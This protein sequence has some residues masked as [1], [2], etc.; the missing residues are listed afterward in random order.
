MEIDGLAL[1]FGSQKVVDLLEDKKYNMVRLRRCITLAKMGRPK[2]ENP[3]DFKV[4]ARLT[5]EEYKKMKE[6]AAK[7]NLTITQALRN[8]IIK[9]IDSKH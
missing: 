6:C 1:L 8:C 4:S 9:M 5:E 2:A 7:D 3:K